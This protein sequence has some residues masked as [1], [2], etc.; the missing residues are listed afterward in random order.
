MFILLFLGL[1]TLSHPHEKREEHVIMF[2]C[3]LIETANECIV[4]GNVWAMTPVRKD[5][6]YGS[7]YMF[8]GQ[9][10]GSAK[11]ESKDHFLRTPKS[12]A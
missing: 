9:K 4:I 7:S 10:T 6:S 11:S 2:W 3:G 1:S 8:C 5:R 12:Q